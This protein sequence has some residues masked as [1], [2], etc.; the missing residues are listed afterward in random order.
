MT[1]EGIKKAEDADDFNREKMICDDIINESLKKDS[2]S[3]NGK[4]DVISEINDIQSNKE[5]A[6][7]KNKIAKYSESFILTNGKQNPENSSPANNT[8]DIDNDNENLADFLLPISGTPNNIDNI[9]SPNSN[10][11]EDKSTGKNADI[12][13][14]NGKASIESKKKRNLFKLEV[15]PFNNDLTNVSNLDTNKHTILSSTNVCK[16]KGRRKK[17]KKKE[18]QQAQ[19]IKKEGIINL[20]LS[21]SYCKSDKTSK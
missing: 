8:M 21:Q 4:I 2:F 7:P 3:V 5:V 19:Q 9:H 15:A 18:E 12:H 16:V 1:L 14:L 20:N 10:L 6:A 13:D 11:P 17:D